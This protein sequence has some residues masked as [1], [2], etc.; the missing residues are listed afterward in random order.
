MT[1]TKGMKIKE[2]KQNTN[3]M[4]ENTIANSSLV[5]EV[6][7]VNKKTYQLKCVEGYMK[8]TECKIAKDFKEEYVDIYGTR[9]TWK[10]V[11]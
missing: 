8:N 10:V 4:F 5:Y 2:T 7:K 1:L 9:T 11:A 3:P 6:V